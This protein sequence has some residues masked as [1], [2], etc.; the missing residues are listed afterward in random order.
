MDQRERA[1]LE[2]AA[3]LAKENNKI[4]KQMRRSARI[5]RVLHALYWL[6]IIGIAVASYY[7]LQPYIQKTNEAYDEARGQLDSLKNIPNPFK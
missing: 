4:L 3:S 7:F 5:G 1:L 2:E 6:V